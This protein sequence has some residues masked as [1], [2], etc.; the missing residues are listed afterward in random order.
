MV[1]SEQ[2]RLAPAALIVGCGYLGIHV[3][4]RLLARGVTVY[5]SSQT[6]GRMPQLFKLGIQPLM[7]SVTQRITLASF[8]PALQAEKLD[9]IYLVPPGRP[10]R[11]PGPQQILL[12]GVTNVINCFKSK[13]HPNLVRRAIV[14]SSTAVYGQGGGAVVNADTAPEPN[15]PRSELLL[16]SESLWLKSHLPA[17]VVRFAG[18][19]GPG[20]I[21]GAAAVRDGS[22]IVGDPRAMLNLIHVHDA[23]DLVLRMLEI[24]NPA[25]VELGCDDA[26][27]ERLEYYEYLATR[28]GVAPPIV[29]DNETAARQ[30]GMNIDRLRRTSSKVCDNKPTCQRTGWRPRYGDF[31]AGL[32]ALF[33]G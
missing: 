24:E 18:L 16:R 8:K 21:I 7:A 2:S 15:N 33:E 5:G 12:D 10:G 17:H 30:L 14:A 11:D 19:Y 9:V 29:L 1:D 32:D 26:P 23:A 22:P 25:P 27:A 20:R 3:A 13:Y 31:R 28:L 4:E 6:P